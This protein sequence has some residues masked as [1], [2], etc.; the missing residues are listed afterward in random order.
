MPALATFIL[1]SLD[2]LGELDDPLV[3]RHDLNEDALV[4]LL[5]L[6][7]LELGLLHVVNRERPA[8][9]GQPG[10]HLQ[11]QRAPGHGEGGRQ[12]H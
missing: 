12:A 9:R 2:R 10:Q 6:F 5:G 7:D 4:G 3:G 8:L 11:S 1:E